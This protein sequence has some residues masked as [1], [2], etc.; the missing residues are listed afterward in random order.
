MAQY[1]TSAALFL[2]AV[3]CPAL[4]S[5]EMIPVGAKVFI[6]QMGGYETYIKAA[7]DKKKVPVTVVES[8]DQADFEISGAAESQKAGAAKILL[9][10]SWHSS[11]E[12]SI[13][14]TS[15]KTSV[16]AFAYSV[17]KANSAHGKRSSAEAC[18]KHL[19]DAM[20]R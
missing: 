6:D 7:I 13:K 3:M 1:H 2:V 12:A 5:Q 15:I 16:I 11:E 17:H 4:R 20:H 14:V 8:R 10:G 18:A 9:S 19:K